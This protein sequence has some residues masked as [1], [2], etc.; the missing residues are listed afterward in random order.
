[1]LR[2]MGDNLM[3]VPNIIPIDDAI[4]HMAFYHKDHLSSGNGCGGAY[5]TRDLNG[6]S[7][8]GTGCPV[9]SREVIHNRTTWRNLPYI[10]FLGNRRY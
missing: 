5:G 7:G 1:M 8:N 6:Y 3:V 9:Y 10:Y 4:D 2:K